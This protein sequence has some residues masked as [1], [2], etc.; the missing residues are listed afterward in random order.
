[1]QRLTLLLTVEEMEEDLVVSDGKV[2]SAA[3]D[4]PENVQSTKDVLE[5]KV[6]NEDVTDKKAMEKDKVMV[7]SILSP[8]APEF[9]PRGGAIK[10]LLAEERVTIDSANLI[11]KNDALEEEIEIDSF[12]KIPG[13][14]SGRPQNVKIGQGS[15]RSKKRK[16]KIPSN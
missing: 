13:D 7:E 4:E 14:D 15:A 2:H 3:K 6:K 1:M 9:I 10:N 11:D 5:E 8:T 16:P 12:D